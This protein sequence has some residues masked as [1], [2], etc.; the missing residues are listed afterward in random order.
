MYRLFDYSF[1]VNNPGYFRMRTYLLVSRDWALR[2]CSRRKDD[3]GFVRRER[4]QDCIIL[5]QGFPLRVV[6]LE[7]LLLEVPRYLPC[8][9]PS[10]RG[11]QHSWTSRFFVPIKSGCSLRQKDGLLWMILP[12]WVLCYRHT[13]TRNLTRCRLASAKIPKILWSA[14][15]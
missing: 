14:N 8:V 13:T 5:F 11:R 7:N 4:D 1:A 9:V 2:L 10:G 12:R 15:N 3:T 6:S